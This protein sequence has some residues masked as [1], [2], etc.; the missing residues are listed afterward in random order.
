MPQAV[1]QS[2]YCSFLP[3]DIKLECTLKVESRNN[4]HTDSGTVKLL[5][6]LKFPS[7]STR[8]IAAFQSEQIHLLGICAAPH[9]LAVGELYS[10]CFINDTVTVDPTPFFDI[11]Q[12]KSMPIF[13]LRKP[14]IL[15]SCICLLLLGLA[16][17]FRSGHVKSFHPRMHQ[18][19]LTEV[20][21]C[22]LTMPEGHGP[23]LE[24]P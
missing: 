19:A 2:S 24:E 1:H 9:N 8:Q 20:R 22:E 14:V 5:H 18:S 23:R 17:V 7:G 11:G 10:I 3:N 6:I 16:S 4:D 12:T 15:T 13:A 21:K